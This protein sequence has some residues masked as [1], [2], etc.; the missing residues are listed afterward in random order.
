MKK[1]AFTLIEL[2][3]VIAI[4]ALLVSLLMPALSKAR[5]QAKK[6]LCLVNMRSW[7][8]VW[9]LYTQ[10]NEGKFNHQVPGTKLGHWIIA[11]MDYYEDPKIRL[12]P[13]ATE[14][15][16]KGASVPFGA[17]TPEI[18]ATLWEPYGVTVDFLTSYGQNL[19]VKS[20]LDPDVFWETIEVPTPYN[21]PLMMDSVN[22]YA[23]PGDDDLAPQ[24]DGDHVN[25]FLEDGS[26]I[27][28]NAMKSVCI[29]RH[30]GE[31]AMVFLDH[32]ADYVG[33]KDLWDLKWR[34]DYVPGRSPGDR[35]NIWPDWMYDLP[36]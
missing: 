30:R 6:T 7:G 12:C 32:H 4:I 36:E 22:V 27:Y 13:E 10:D 23:A 18:E 9:K 2:L 21:I 26:P 31:I 1:R 16:I 14:P 25:G 15:Y 11:S 3:V 33:L 17:W 35:F 20:T 24:Y 34:R 5:A 29:N 8:L 19:F 28:T